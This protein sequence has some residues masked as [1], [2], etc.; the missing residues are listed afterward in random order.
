MQVTQSCCMF[1]LSDLI[2]VDAYRS[3]QAAATAR[4]KSKMEQAVFFGDRT[5][6]S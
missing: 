1:C 4:L 3:P 2:R 6:V 5:E